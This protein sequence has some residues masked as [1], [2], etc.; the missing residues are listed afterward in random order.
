MLKIPTGRRQTS[1]PR[2]DLNPGP[3][4]FTPPPDDDDDNEGNDDDLNDDKDN[5]DNNVHLD[6]GKLPSL[7][8]GI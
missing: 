6:F 4:D 5:A 2:R 8:D 3:P 7:S 1:W